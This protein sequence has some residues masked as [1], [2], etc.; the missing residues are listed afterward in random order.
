MAGGVETDF[1]T[2]AQVIAVQVIDETAQ[3][4]VTHEGSVS[5]SF[6]F[7]YNGATISF[8]QFQ[9][10][11]ADGALYAALAASSV[12]AASITWNN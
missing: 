5:A 8:S 2:T 4:I 11:I 7:S 3:G 12:A 10:V 6:V 9:E 1:P